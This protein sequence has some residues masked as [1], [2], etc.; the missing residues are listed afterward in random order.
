[1]IRYWAPRAYP[2]YPVKRYLL[3]IGYGRAEQVVGIDDLNA[4]LVRRREEANSR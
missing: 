4:Y 3:H 1:M 2:A